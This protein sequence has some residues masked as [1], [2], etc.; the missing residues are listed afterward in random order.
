MRLF[1][2]IAHCFFGKNCENVSN[3]PLFGVRLVVVI[4]ALLMNTTVPMAAQTSDK[5]VK[6]VI[7]AWRL[8]NDL[9]VADTVVIDSSFLNLP[10]K[11]MPH[12]YSIANSYNG[13]L[14]SPIESK[15]YFDRQDKI[16]FLFAR[17][18]MPYILTPGDVRFYNTTTPYSTIAYKKGFTTYREEN[19]L[20]FSFTAN[21]TPDFNLGLTLNYL[22]AVGHYNL[23]SGKRFNG[24]VFGSYDGTH[25]GCRGAVTFNTLSNFENGGIV[26]DSVDYLS[27]SLKTEDIPVN[28]EAMSEYKYISGFLN[29]HYSICVERERRVTPDSVTIDYVPVTTFM[30]TFEVNQS[31]KRYVEQQADQGFYAHRYF[32]R[33]NTR[34]TANVLNIRNTLAV[35]F[36]EEFNKWLRFGATVYAVN[37]CQRYAFSVPETTDSTVNII[38]ND[39]DFMLANPL[40]LHSDSLTGHQWVNNTWVGGSIYKNTG[41][42][43]RYGFTGDVCVVGYKLG[44][45]KVNGHINTDFR[46]GKDTMRI[47]A[48]AYVKNEQPDYFLQH[49]RSNHYYWN[50]DFR[51]T[52]RFYVG[53]EWAY[54]TKYVQPSINV[55]FE[56]LTHYIYF[57]EDGLPVQHEGNI[58]VLAVDAQLNFR[59]KRFGM[60]NNVVYQLSSDKALP[61]PSVALYHNIY[62]RDC[63]FKAL[64]VQIGVD[65][66]Y[67]TAYYAPLLNPATGQFCIQ[68]KEKVGNYPILN[69][70]A[71]FYVRSLRLK[72]FAHFTHFNQYFM[73]HKNYYSM[74]GYPLNPPIFRAGLAWH[75]YK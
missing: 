20:D 64:D 65:M 72:L 74:S 47:S 59:T 18:Y 63:W 37:E 2:D 50:N 42:Y 35:T 14:V 21:L 61:L 67:H 15:I 36:E 16:D 33:R 68:H 46:V 60:D 34:D 45:F 71:N 75:F 26:S 38:N 48:S 40:L 70:Y 13:N 11:E 73:K 1:K 29:H 56:N 57:G 66:R 41:K 52:Y 23:Q 12:T 53:G 9:G 51:K 10:M 28:L 55:G 24:S 7:R 6:T 17:A 25:Y 43:I 39:Y 49:Y 22:N 27:S 69:V 3:T 58:Q 5:D 31:T 54:P 44:E 19:D 4:C 62:Y 30:H 32:D 8:P